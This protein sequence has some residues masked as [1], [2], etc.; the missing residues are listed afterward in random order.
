MTAT[1]DLV[2][3]LR[4]ITL[5]SWSVAFATMSEAADTIEALQA[6]RV[7]LLSLVARC[8]HSMRCAVEWQKTGEGRPPSQT[9]MLEIDD[10]LKALD[11]ARTGSKT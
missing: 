10:A 4:G 2:Q 3:R 7:V 5:E 8:R 9:C 11:A 1:T 6:E